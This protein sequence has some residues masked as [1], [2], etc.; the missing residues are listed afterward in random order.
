[1]SGFALDGWTLLA[2]LLSAIALGILGGAALG[3]F[4]AS[5]DLQRERAKAWERGAT[6]MQRAIERVWIPPTTLIARVRNPYVAR[7]GLAPEPPHIVIPTPGGART[8]WPHLEAAIFDQDAPTSA[9][10]AI[11]LRGDD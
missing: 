8:P 11:E 10:V 3:Y 7:P 9:A 1:M 6:S 5:S 4:T 2:A